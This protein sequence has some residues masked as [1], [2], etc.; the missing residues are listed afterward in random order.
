M[1]G[2]KTIS[3]RL[4]LLAV[5]W[6]VLITSGLALVWRY[7][8]TPGRDSGPPSVWPGI[9]RIARA[10][11]QP[12]LIVFAHPKCPCT[13]ATFAELARIQARCADRL[14]IHV[15]FVRP[16]GVAAGWERTDL[17]KHA[18]SIPGAVVELDDGG[19]EATR[20]GVGTSGYSLLYG[21]DGRLQY[22]GGITAARGHEG[23]NPGEDAVVS[24]VLT[25]H[26]EQRRMP[27]F[28]CSL[29]GAVNSTA[30][31]SR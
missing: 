26:S 23:D 20:F 19:V 14:D 18:Q 31:V 11:K 10:T 15:M 25:G 13:R 21:T 12:K 22:A 9:S 4:S 3:F 2:L 29:L 8:A 16:S 28:G 17:W 1:S 24:F 30:A 5:V 27:A 7:E 6:L